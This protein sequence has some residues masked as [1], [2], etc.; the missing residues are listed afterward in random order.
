MNNLVFY[1]QEVSLDPNIG[2][3]DENSTLST[4]TTTTKPISAPASPCSKPRQTI[5]GKTCRFHGLLVLVIAPLLFPWSTKYLFQFMR[6]QHSAH[7]CSLLHIHPITFLFFKCR[8]Y[9]LYLHKRNQKK[10]PKRTISH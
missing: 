4:A 6:I 9:K 2:K 8:K 3:I 1:I 10:F 7:W 5:S